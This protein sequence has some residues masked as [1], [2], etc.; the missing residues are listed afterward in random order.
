[1]NATSDVKEASKQYAAGRTCEMKGGE[2]M[3]WDQRTTGSCGWWTEQEV[4]GS[5]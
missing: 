3:G 1:M 5:I 4:K 2:W